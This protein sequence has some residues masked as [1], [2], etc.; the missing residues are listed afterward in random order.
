MATEV[1]EG[2]SALVRM[3]CES[4][5][6]QEASKFTPDKFPWKR[7]REKPKLIRFLPSEAIFRITIDE[8]TSRRG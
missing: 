8:R 3:P 7:N 6:E 5:K 4:L 1:H 2:F